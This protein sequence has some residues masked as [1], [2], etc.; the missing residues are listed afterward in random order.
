[1]IGQED[2]DPLTR[3]DIAQSLA[4]N[5]ESEQQIAERLAVIARFEF[6]D[7][8]R[9]AHFSSARYWLNAGAEASDGDRLVIATDEYNE[10]ALAGLT[11]N[12]NFDISS[13]AAVALGQPGLAMNR[14]LEELQRN[15]HSR[16]ALALRASLERELRPSGWQVSP[17]FEELG[18]FRFTGADFLFSKR[19]ERFHLD[20]RLRHQRATPQILQ[21]PETFAESSIDSTLT[22]NNRWGTGVIGLGY[23]QGDERSLASINWQQEFAI[24]RRN[25]L[26]ITLEHNARLQ[27]SLI[28]I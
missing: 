11:L 4:K 2:T 18:D 22:Y 13:Q 8:L 1:M 26:L 5:P 14:T 21:G 17:V 10:D 12:D 25:S 19:F 23:T 16:P 7:A 3:E 6:S 27:L 20:T 28:H 9:R 24:D 15:P